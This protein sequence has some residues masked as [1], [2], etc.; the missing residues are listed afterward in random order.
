MAGIDV[1][2]QSKRSMDHSLPL[3]PFIDFL[4]CVISFLL[5]TAV[6]SQMARLNADAAVPGRSERPPEDPKDRTLH[7]E[8]KTTAQGYA[9]AL[10]WKQG[11]RVLETHDVPVDVAPDFTSAPTY[12]KL[13]ET[14]TQAWSHNPGRHFAATDMQLD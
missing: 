2:G 13:A 5:I 11:S 9:F 14:I 8:V 4:L 1:G 3:V 12:P 7:V 6:W 10:A